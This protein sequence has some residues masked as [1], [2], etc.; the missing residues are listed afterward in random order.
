MEI[1]WKPF[2]DYYRV[3]NTGVV[4]SRAGRHGKAKRYDRPDERIG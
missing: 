4:Q 3:S 2:G 1:M